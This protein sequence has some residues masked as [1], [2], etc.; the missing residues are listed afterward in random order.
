MKVDTFSKTKKIGPE[1][2]AVPNFED[3]SD[4]AFDPGKSEIYI[5]S[6]LLIYFSS[7]ITEIQVVTNFQANKIDRKLEIIY[8]F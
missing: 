8:Q 6:I 3:A 1:T 2:K 4:T 7:K 5:H